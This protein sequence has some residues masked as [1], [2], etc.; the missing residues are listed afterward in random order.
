M[1]ML[2]GWKAGNIILTK[3]NLR[4]LTGYNFKQT[5]GADSRLAS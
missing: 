1:V 2:G 4:C 5:C 3:T